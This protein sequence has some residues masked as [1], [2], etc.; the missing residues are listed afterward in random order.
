MRWDAVPNAGSHILASGQLLSLR[1]P[2]PRNCSQDTVVFERVCAESFLYHSALLTLLDPSLDRI[3]ALRT[4]LDLDGYFFDPAHPDANDLRS[5]ISTQPILEASYQ[6]YLLIADITRLARAAPSSSPEDC[7]LWFRRRE[8]FQR[9]ESTVDSD[10]PALLSN[11]VAKLYAE[12]IRVLFLKAH[13][14]LPMNEAIGFLEVASRRGVALIENIDFDE[15][16]APFYRLWP[17]IV[18]GSLAIDPSEKDKIRAKLCFM[19]E[20][21][22]EGPVILARHRLESVWALDAP[23]H[24]HDR[25]MLMLTHLTKLLNGK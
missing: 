24:S 3:C 13:P 11:N 8:D 21:K 15:C 10:R 22:M 23:S 25:G 4:R 20:S 17:V 1:S 2:R 7:A 16:F 5:S 9:W 12:A 14:E 6:F 19:S 18:I